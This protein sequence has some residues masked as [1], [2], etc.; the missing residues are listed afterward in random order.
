MILCIMLILLC[1][2]K[3]L[4]VR[5]I[6]DYLWPS[7][8]HIIHTV[9]NLFFNWLN[10]CMCVCMCVFTLFHLLVSSGGTASVTH[11]RWLDQQSFVVSIIRVL[12]QV[13]S[14]PFPN[15]SYFTSKDENSSPQLTGEKRND[16]MLDPPKDDIYWSRI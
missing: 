6:T 15:L 2:T 7:V 12:C 8:I 5:W 14:S 10:K 1:D 13:P 16:I 9:T 11:V 3:P 4:C